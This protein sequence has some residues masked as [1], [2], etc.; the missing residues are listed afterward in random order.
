MESRSIGATENRTLMRHV[1]RQKIG[2]RTRAGMAKA[3][4]AGKHIGRPSIS[5][6]LQE[7][8]AERIAAGETPYRIAKDLG[9]DRHTVAKYARPFEVSAAA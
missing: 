2:E 5:P 8:I 3:K 9:I 6:K 4:A 1:L 7:R